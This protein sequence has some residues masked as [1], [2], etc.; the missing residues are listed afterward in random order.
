MSLIERVEQGELDQHITELLDSALNT[1][2]GNYGI[3]RALRSDDG[4]ILDFELVHHNH[5]HP[6][7]KSRDG[8]VRMTIDGVLPDHESDRMRNILRKALERFPLDKDQMNG[9]EPGWHNNHENTA[10]ALSQDEVL[11]IY[12]DGASTPSPTNQV[13][14]LLDHDPLTELINRMLIKD[15]ITAGLKTLQKEDEPFVFGYLNIDNFGQINHDYGYLFGD[16]VLRAFSE[17]IQDQ[18]GEGDHLVRLTGDEFAMVLHGFRGI[19]GLSAFSKRLME[20]AKRGWQIDGKHIYL[21]FSAGFVLVNNPEVSENE[22]YQ[23]SN[24]QMY[25]MKNQGKNG[26][27]LA[28][29]HSPTIPAA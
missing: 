16:A 3:W 26:A 19:S 17:S 22:V 9:G 4:E 5:V 8:Q 13:Q 25:K 6:V 7:E 11:V 24:S 28:I 29:F 20:V 12:H 23:L 18:L 21:E 27:I 14:L 2:L 10:L 1:F 15:S